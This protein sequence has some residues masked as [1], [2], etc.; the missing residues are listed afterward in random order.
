MMRYHNFHIIKGKV[1]LY[2]KQI[3]RLMKEYRMFDEPVPA[4]SDIF[5]TPHQKF[6]K[7]M[8]DIG[9]CETTKQRKLRIHT[10]SVAAEIISTSKVDER[11]SLEDATAGLLEYADY[12]TDIATDQKYVQRKDDNNIVPFNNVEMIIT[13]YFASSPKRRTGIVDSLTIKSVSTIFLNLEIP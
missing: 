3:K 9:I 7:Y 5:K 10:E 12:F 8:C 11:I 2:N 4:G 13:S 1:G 6:V